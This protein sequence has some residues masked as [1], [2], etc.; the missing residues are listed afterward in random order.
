LNHVDGRLVLY[1]GI[2]FALRQSAKL[3]KPKLIISE[4]NGK[5]TLKTESTL[6]TSSYEF[7]P[8]DEFD[9]VRLDGETVKVSRT[10]SNGTVVRHRCASSP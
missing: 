8:G 4:N 10:T 7:T 5:W 2:G 3:I 1:Q 6:K 9:E